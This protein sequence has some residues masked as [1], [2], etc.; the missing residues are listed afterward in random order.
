MSILLLQVL[1]SRGSPTRFAVMAGDFYVVS[2]VLGP[3]SSLREAD[4]RGL[5]HLGDGQELLPRIE[6]RIEKTL[7]QLLGETPL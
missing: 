2:V 5:W 7:R 1:E 6:A 3:E 4:A